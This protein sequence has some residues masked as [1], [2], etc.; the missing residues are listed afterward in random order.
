[1]HWRLGIKIQTSAKSQVKSHVIYA[2]SHVKFRDTDS[3]DSSLESLTR[4]SRI[5]L[6]CPASYF[7]S[8]VLT[9]V[10]NIQLNS[11]DSNL[12][13]QRFSDANNKNHHLLQKYVGVGARKGI[14]SANSQILGGTVQ[15][16]LSMENGR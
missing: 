1:M 12:Q 6:K 14:R 8:R 3:S 10:S 7:E 9:Q 16:V 13:L 4:V 2:K 5:Q 11:L 15:P